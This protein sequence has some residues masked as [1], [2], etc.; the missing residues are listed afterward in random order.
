[1]R[2]LKRKL[3]SALTSASREPNQQQINMEGMPINGQRRLIQVHPRKSDMHVICHSQPIPCHQQQQRKNKC[4]QSFL[5]KETMQHCDNTQQW[6]TRA[7]TERLHK[8]KKKKKKSHDT[9]DTGQ[10]VI[11]WWF[12]S[13]RRFLWGLCL[14]V[15]LCQAFVVSD[16][17]CGSLYCHG[18]GQVSWTVH[19]RLNRGADNQ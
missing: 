2:S 6:D 12:T 7:I 4:C 9:Q 17:W 11:F 1:M 3:L 16:E 8:K 15:C 14:N 10:D 18:L 13:H 5:I 19:L